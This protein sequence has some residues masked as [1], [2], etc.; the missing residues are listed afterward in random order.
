[1]SADAAVWRGSIFRGMIERA[2]MVTRHLRLS[3]QA[4]GR[5]ERAEK[6]LCMDSYT[7]WTT[8]QETSSIPDIRFQ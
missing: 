3:V 1:M 6:S 2:T 5:M 4:R 8:V 7:V